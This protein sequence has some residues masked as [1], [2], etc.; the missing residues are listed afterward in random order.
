MLFNDS[1]FISALQFVEIPRKSFYVRFYKEKQSEMLHSCFF[2]RLTLNTKKSDVCRCDFKGRDRIL[3]SNIK[4]I[5]KT[6]N[7]YKPI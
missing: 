1:L 7:I 2:Q 5:T 3:E 6:L 4:L